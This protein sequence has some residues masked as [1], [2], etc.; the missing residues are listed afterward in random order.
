MKTNLNLARIWNETSE[1]KKCLAI[2]A[3]HLINL[4]YTYEQ[5][6]AER[7]YLQTV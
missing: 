3:K 6:G 1:K 4:T 7:V 2:I 5:Q